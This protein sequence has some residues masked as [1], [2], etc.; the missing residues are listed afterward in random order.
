MEIFAGLLS[1]FHPF[2]FVLIIA[3]VFVGIIFGALPGLT[4]AAAVALFLSVTFGL[5]PV[6]G[7][8]LLI[9]LYIGGLIPAILLKIPGTPASM[10][11]TLEGCKMAENGE[12][13]K[14][15]GIG[16][17]SSFIGGSIGTIVLIFI[18]PPIATF[19]IRFGP[20]EYF[21]ISV[22]SLSMISTLVSSSVIRGLS[23]GLLGIMIALFGTSP[24]DG[25]RRL[26][27]GYHQMDAGLGLLPVLI[28][29][30]AVAELLRSAEKEYTGKLKAQEFKLKGFGFSLKE[31]GKQMVNLFRSTFIGVGI[32]ILPGIGPGTSNLIS[33]FTAK[34]QSKHPEKFGTGIMDGLIASEAA[35]NATTGGALVPLLF[36]TQANLVYAIFGAVVV[37][38]LG[39]LVLMYL[40]IRTFIKVLEVPSY[41][42]LPVIM[43][44]CTIGAYSV[45][46]RVFDVISMLVLG[47]IGYLIEKLGFSLMPIVLGFVL[48]PIVELNLQRGLMAS[49]NSFL[50]ILSSPVAMFFLGVTALTIIWT[51]IKESNRKRQGRLVP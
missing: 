43:A 50:P 48:G 7:M 47:I 51:A 49:H 5:D 21:S 25:A 36:T 38:N 29:L 4:A 18:A 17:V 3:G 37:A 33:Y 19:A 6:N 24:V 2:T 1:A 41:I 26:T 46:G 13:G 20:W 8:S 39:M 9:G 14:A 23:G 35:N 28:G 32:G 27:F 11:T 34:S 40:N 45:N 22:F 16:I 31:Y 42:L 44:V 10:A 15:L 12:A 30:F